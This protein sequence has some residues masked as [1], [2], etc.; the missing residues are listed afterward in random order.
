MTRV[1]GRGAQTG[2]PTRGQEGGEEKRKTN[3]ENRRKSVA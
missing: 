1:G 2:Y 3:A